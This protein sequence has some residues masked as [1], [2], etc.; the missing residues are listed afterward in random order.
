[1]RVD[2]AR[3]VQGA[4]EGEYS[5]NAVGGMA[6][7][8]LDKAIL[9][10]AASGNLEAR[11]ENAMEYYGMSERK[12]CLVLGQG[13]PTQRYVSKQMGDEELLRNSISSLASKYGR[14]GYKRIT[15]LLNQDG[16]KVNHKR[17]FRIWREEGLK[18][19]SKQHKKARLLFDNGDCVRYRSEYKDHVWSY[20]SEQKRQAVV[21]D[22]DGYRRVYS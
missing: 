9:K 22:Y 17:I 16:W 20:D 11:L 19:P 6:G 10:D 14:C 7:L 2:Q 3:T 5:V 1:L 15:A 13:R 12:A 18:V 4:G 8:S 21:S